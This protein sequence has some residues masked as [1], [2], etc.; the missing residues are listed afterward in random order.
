M[1]KTLVLLAVCV[2]TIALIACGK[3]DNAV[4]GGANARSTAAGNMTAAAR[5][6]Q[7]IDGMSARSMAAD[8]MTAAVRELQAAV[9]DMDAPNEQTFFKDVYNGAGRNAGMNYGANANTNYGAGATLRR[10]GRGNPSSRRGWTQDTVMNNNGAAN[11]GGTTNAANNAGYRNLRADYSLNGNTTGLNATDAAGNIN[12]SNTVGSMNGAAYSGGLNAANTT[13]TAA[14]NNGAYTNAP[15]NGTYANTNSGANANIGNSANVNISNTRYDFA[16]YDNRANGTNNTATN[17]TNTVNGTNNT[18][19]NN[20]NTV[21]GMNNTTANN[22]NTV[23]G[24]SNTAANNTNASNDTNAGRANI[25]NF[26]RRADNYYF[27]N[28]NLL[29][30]MY[31]TTGRLF[32]GSKYRNRAAAVCARIED[33]AAKIRSG[34]IEL[35]E[36]QIRSIDDLTE[37]IKENT[38]YLRDTRGSIANAVSEL[39]KSRTATAGIGAT[40][41]AGGMTNNIGN[42]AA[43]TNGTTAAVGNLTANGGAIGSA[44]PAN[45]DSIGNANPSNVGGSAFDAAG[46]LRLNCKINERRA[47]VKTALDAAELILMQYRYNGN[48]NAA[49][50]TLNRAYNGSAANAYNQSAANNQSMNTAGNGA[51]ANRNTAA[52]NGA[53]ANRNATAG[54]NRAATQNTAATSYPD[55]NS[56]TPSDPKG[57]APLNGQAA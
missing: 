41:T 44:N 7:T 25:R 29:Y 6:L 34:E 1:K 42:T 46:M 27:Y 50:N 57:L 12:R 32:D 10:P 31:R 33:F 28:Q 4:F 26:N 56:P 35:S 55:T 3:K 13:D 52:G 21:N 48:M 54:L 38:R 40:G 16:D 23:N 15:N 20:T 39:K 22:T 8:N 19:A 9:N 36:E 37:V 53:T 51:T 49:A 45:G 17:N 14:G 5:E 18:T 30:K 2:F 47:R 11:N 24:T 43:D